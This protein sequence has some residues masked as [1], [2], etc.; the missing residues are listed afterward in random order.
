M[1]VACASNETIAQPPS[2]L[3]AEA[4]PGQPFGVGKI[5]FRTGQEG[6]L[7]QNTGG[8]LLHEAENRVFYPAFTSGL[9]S[10][11]FDRPVVGGVQSVWFLFRG[12]QPLTISLRADESVT[13]TVT[14]ERRR[15]PARERLAFQS[16][17]RQ[18]NAASNERREAGDYPPLV[19]TYL[20]SM[21]Q[22]RLGL[23][24]PLLERARERRGDEFQETFNLLFDV[25]S[26]RAESIRQL[27]TTPPDADLA[28]MPVP[29]PATWSAPPPLVV[30]VEIEIEAIARFVPVECFY[31]RFGNWNNQLWLKRLMSE[32]G[33]DLSQMVSLRGHRGGDTQKMLDQLVLESSQIDDWFGGNL[34]EDVAVI[35]TDLYVEEGP[36]NAV[37]LLAKNDSLEDRISK[38]RTAYASQ[39]A[40]DGVT[41]TEVPVAGRTVT[42]LASPDNRVRSFHAVVDRCHITSS[43]QRIIERFFEAADGSGSLVGNAEFRGARTVLPLEHDHTVFI[44][45]SRAFFENLLSPRYQ[46]ELARRNRSL[47][48]IQLLQLA[49]WAAVHEGYADDDIGQ[50]IQHGF[51]PESFNQLPD[52]SASNWIDGAWHD[53]MRGRRGYY[54]PIADVDVQSITAAESAWLNERLAFFQ[55]ELR[56]VDPLLL[57]FKRFDLGNNV[58]RVVVD[59]R[60]APFGKEKYGWLGNL[61]GPPM[62]V[63]IRGGPD[64]L[65]AFQASLSGN[66]LSRGEA[67]QVFA[68]VQSDVPPRT[69]L[70]PASFL[71][72]LQL[73]RTTP[74]YLGAWPTPG[75]LDRLPALGARP[76]AAGYTYSRILD[77]WRLQFDD[78]SLISF[79][80][81]RLEAARGWIGVQPAERPAQVRLR[82]GDVANSNLRQ[83]ANVVYF[84]RAWQTSIANV[85]LLNLMIQQLGIPAE[86][87]LDQAEHLLGVTLVCPLGGEYVFAETGDHSMAW[88]STVWPSFDDPQMPS[89]YTA[90]PIAWFRGMS[91][92]VYQLQ[93]QFV[94]HATLDIARGAGPGSDGERGGFWEVLPDFGA[95]KGFSPL[96]EL[97]P[98]RDPA[99]TDG[100]LRAPGKS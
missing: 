94:V 58:E 1:A 30:P 29:P 65:I 25:E 90:P 80:R 5:S 81:N 79:D 100:E 13:V 82:V 51:L 56:E 69:S 33:G 38:R 92:D 36:S 34:I 20:A 22:R 24:E 41:L 85:R 46:I 52:G 35:G 84:D 99:D 26:I 11:V 70:Q 47:A 61:L 88:Q 75:Y 76:D 32:Y 4:W 78:F 14:P 50:M 60:V 45:L 68:A 54:L 7:I 17:W 97:P 21:L 16:W 91:L 74:G 39:H 71:E 63:E 3:G 40:D 18:F 12:E 72:M 27:M 87:A 73:L 86:T 2:I 15:R 42:L 43:S 57:A 93:T 77:V 67:H 62:T 48:N 89:E 6:R 55:E 49:Q 9:L 83:W 64:D 98:A 66:L 31:L 8:L 44:Y 19:E 10:K 96:E 53:S 37:L 23:N 28:V 95:F 59:G